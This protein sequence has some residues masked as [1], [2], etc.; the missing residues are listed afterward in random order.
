MKKPGLEDITARITE[1]FMND[2]EVLLLFVFGSAASG[3][4]TDQ[5]DL[6]IAVLFRGTPEFSDIV[7]ITGELSE[8]TGMEVDLVA[9]NNSSPVLRMQVLKNGRLITCREESV[10]ND[11]FVRTVKEYDD[12]KRIRRET[13]EAVL[14]G[15]I[16]A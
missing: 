12:L 2:K 5:S 6:D 4:L 10:F 11:F 14:R 8:I 7:R 9:L 16:Y 3:R 13:E 15:R 1:R